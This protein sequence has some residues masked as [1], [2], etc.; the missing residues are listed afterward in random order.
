MTGSQQNTTSSFPLADKVTGR[1]GAENA[2]LSD[3]EL[4]HAVCSAN[5]CDCLYDLR[6][7][8]ATVTA[9]NEERAL[10]AFGDGKEDTGDEGLGIIGL[11][12]DD[13][14]FAKTRTRYI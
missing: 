11:L 4:L 13:D 12:E 14:L 3:Q 7:V 1:W 8:V 9:D 2:V 6:V 10:H 5:L